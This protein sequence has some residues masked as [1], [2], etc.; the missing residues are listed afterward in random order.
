MVPQLRDFPV[1]LVAQSL[2]PDPEQQNHVDTHTHTQAESSTITFSDMMLQAL[3]DGNHTD[4]VA[5]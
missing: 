1:D 2:Q 4:L 3:N 5:L